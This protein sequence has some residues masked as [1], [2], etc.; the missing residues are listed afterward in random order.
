M[1]SLVSRA[2]APLAHRD[3][4][5]KIDSQ[6]RR[7]QR[8]HVGAALDR[9]RVGD[10]PSVWRASITRLAAITDPHAYARNDP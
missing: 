4:R 1:I 5:R 7:D 8:A 3:S 6:P 2:P 9:G 10:Q